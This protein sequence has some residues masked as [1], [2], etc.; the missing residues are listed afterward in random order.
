MAGMVRKPDNLRKKRVVK[1][2]KNKSSIFGLDAFSDLL[3]WPQ[4]G[5]KQKRR[6]SPQNPPV[7]VRGESM[8]RPTSKNT[9]HSQPSVR[10]RYDVA[11][12]NVPGAVMTLPALPNIKIGWRLISFMLVILCGFGIYMIWNSPIFKVNSIQI[13]GLQRVMKQEINGIMNIEG[14][15]SFVLNPS[16]LEQSLVENFP[17]FSAVSLSIGFPDYVAIT[18]TERVPVL[19]W[20]QEGKTL[21][22]DEDGIAFPTRGD[23]VDTLLPVVLASSPPPGYVPDQVITDT[24]NTIDEGNPTFLDDLSEKK[25]LKSYRVLTPEMV[26][27]VLQLVDYAPQDVPLLYTKEHGFGWADNGGWDVYFGDPK[28]ILMKLSIYQRIIG[29]LDDKDTFPALISV[30]WVDAP[31]YRL[32]K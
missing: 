28:D 7:M 5:K 6:Q 13:H 31:Y 30:E 10:R 23:E 17:E 12:K 11:V 22:V 8:A 19:V 3:H 29:L 32:E 4:S 26:T 24:Q 18:V 14:K 9:R 21:L 20:Q 25:E 27:S 15:P 16:Q 1:D 2:S